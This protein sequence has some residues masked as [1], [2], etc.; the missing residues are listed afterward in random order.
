M[1]WWVLIWALL[2]VC[3]AV[4]LGSRLWELWGQSKD[5]GREV[6]IAQERLEQVQGQLDQLGE[7]IT[8]PEQLAVFG[9]PAALRRQ[10]QHDLARQRHERA[11]RRAGRRPTWARH[12]D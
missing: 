5:F 6:V 1:W 4:Y 2:L 12:V 8:A 7:Q 9:D 11:R 3:A 10:R